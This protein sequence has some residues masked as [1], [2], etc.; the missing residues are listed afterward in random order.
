MTLN[1][2][3]TALG[4]CSIIH[5]GFLMWWF[6]AMAVLHDWV[7]AIHTIWFNIPVETFDAI[8]YAGMAIYKL[9]IF[10]FAIIPYIGLH[11]ASKKHPA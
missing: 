7:Y 2:V 6:F 1:I 10:M 4:W 3:K 8:H 5:M 9:A 11:I